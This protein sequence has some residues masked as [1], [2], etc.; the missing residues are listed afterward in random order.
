MGMPQT[1]AQKRASKKYREA[2]R[3]KIN[4]YNKKYKEASKEKTKEYNKQYKASNKDKIKEYNK[5]NED[6]LKEYTIEYR[7][8]E[9]GKKNCIINNW[10]NALKIKFDDKNEAE[11]Y[12]NTYIN[13]HRCNWCD[14]DFKDNSDRC[15]DHCHT[16]GLPRSIICRSCNVKDLVPC[17]NC[18]L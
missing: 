18:L 12:Y 13:T 16:C 15:M 9:T 10:I 6:K 5:K 3:Y 17:V 7:K 1:E 4:E 2:N 11:Y 14:K 8:T